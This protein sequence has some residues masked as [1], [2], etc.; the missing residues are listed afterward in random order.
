MNLIDNPNIDRLNQILDLTSARESV[1]TNNI[2]N[3]DTPGYH[4]RDINFASELERA[5]GGLQLASFGPHVSHVGGLVERPDGNNVNVEREGLLMAQTQLQ[6]NVGV[7]LLKLEFH[8]L[9]TAINGGG[10]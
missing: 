3:V 1:I 8:R 4:T 5:Q 2:A 6:F 9:A 7:Q 10:N